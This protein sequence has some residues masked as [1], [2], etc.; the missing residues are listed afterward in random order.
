MN[1]DGPRITPRPNHTSRRKEITMAKLD[2]TELIPVFNDLAK[3]RESMESI[4]KS[5]A[6]LLSTA[7]DEDE[8]AKIAEADEFYRQHVVYPDGPIPDHTH[9]D[10]HTKL[11]PGSWRGDPVAVETDERKAMEL[12]Q[13]IVTAMRSVQPVPFI[14]VIRAMHTQMTLETRCP[15][16][17][18][19][20]YHQVKLFDDPQA[21]FL[22]VCKDCGTANVAV[23][24]REGFIPK[25]SLEPDAEPLA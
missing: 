5:V 14:D 20:T 6:G 11:G 16:C 9:P 18:G 17:D 21:G 10:L 3:T 25:L 24:V 8:A 15:K 13:A 4:L 22:M 19:W 2:H 1:P 7:E 12:E 23:Q